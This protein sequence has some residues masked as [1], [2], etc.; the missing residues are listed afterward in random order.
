[1]EKAVAIKYDNS[2][3]APFILA[4]G[5][6]ELAAKLKT[7]AKQNGVDLARI[8]HVADAIIDMPVGSLIPEELYAVI[9][10]L[11]VFIRNLKEPR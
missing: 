9:A 2:L 1:M 5:R 7:I 8:P 10:E 6:G 4:K 11:L 3:P